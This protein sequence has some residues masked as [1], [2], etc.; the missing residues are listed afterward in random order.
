[1]R[2]V[3]GVVVCFS[4]L[5]VV[6]NAL[7]PPIPGLVDLG[8]VDLGVVDLGIAVASAAAGVA[9]QAPRIQELEKDLE[10]AHS[11]LNEVSSW[12]LLAYDVML[13]SS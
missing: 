4:S 9:S 6:A 10:L 1:M 2:L 8:L 11:A 12:Q 3:I 7:V 5:A 13:H